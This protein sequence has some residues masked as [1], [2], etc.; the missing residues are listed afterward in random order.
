MGV[1]RR[2]VA[3]APAPGASAR[4]AINGHA[5]STSDSGGLAIVVVLHELVGFRDDACG[6]FDVPAWRCRVR[7]HLWLHAVVLRKLL[8]CL[9]KRIFPFGFSSM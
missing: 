8:P 1:I 6:V 2:D 5:E 3:V 9:P 7:T 4:D